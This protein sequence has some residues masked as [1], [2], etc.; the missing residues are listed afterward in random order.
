MLEPTAE[1]AAAAA[2]TA[3]RD[4]VRTCPAVSAAAIV[5]GQLVFTGEAGSSCEEEPCKADSTLFY[6]ASISKTVTALAV[7]QAAE[8]GE[9]DIDADISKYVGQRIRNPHLDS[10]QGDDAVLTLR[11]LLQHRSGLQDGEDALLPGQW[12]SESDD[13]NIPLAEYVR[14]RLLPGGDAYDPRIWSSGAAPGTAPYHYSNAGFSLAGWAL[15]S[16]TGQ[17]LAELTKERI[18]APLGM[19]RTTFTLREATDGRGTLAPPTPPGHPYGVAETPAAAMVSTATDLA[20]YLLALTAPPEASPLLRPDSLRELLPDSF[21][22]G[23]AWWG[24]DAAYGEKTDL[25]VW[26]HGG[27]MQ[28]VRTHVHLWPRERAAVVVLTN[29]ENEEGKD[30]VADALRRLVLTTAAAA[31]AP[32]P[33][34]APAPAPASNPIAVAVAT[35]IPDLSALPLLLRAVNAKDRR[36]VSAHLATYPLHINALD[37]SSGGGAAVHWASLHG[38]VPMIKLLADAGGQLD[39][40]AE[41]SGMLPLHWAC[42]TGHLEMLSFLLS[43]DCDINALDVRQTTPLMI[44]VQYGHHDVVDAL[45]A[46]PGCNRTAVDQDGDDAMHWA[47]YK[48]HAP[49]IAA[50]YKLGVRPEL[51]DAFGSTC[52]HLAVGQGSH[53]AA[54]WM[55]KNV[56]SACEM[57]LGSR[58]A[59]GRTPYEVAVGNH[60]DSM[61]QLLE[62]YRGER[63]AW[64]SFHLWTL[65]ASDWLKAMLTKRPATQQQQR[66]QQQQS[67]PKV[68]HN[69]LLFGHVPLRWEAPQAQDAM[70]RDPR[71]V[72]LRVAVADD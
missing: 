64:A 4:L 30:A 11:H 67:Q 68:E 46:Q 33:E 1:T 7:L 57:M 21:T 31:S 53:A 27:F 2:S 47:C 14:A 63:G 12:R 17:A 40:P 55:L 59:K 38:D 51:Q 54:W 22:G 70:E 13:C 35:P 18:F 34:P 41:N 72:E 58:D 49:P 71:E 24:R 6:T 39:L 36:A 37:A 19:S 44:A 62:A 52:L 5:D 3:M 29:G 26:S 16:A 60:R 45:L 10:Q 25:A 8:R 28:G 20:K 56:P 43:K 23:L 48:D 9:L 42:T 66:R 15:E 65:D 61:R 50:L 32:A 69:M